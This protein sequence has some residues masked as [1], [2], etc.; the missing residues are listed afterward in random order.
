MWKEARLSAKG[1][2]LFTLKTTISIFFVIAF[3]LPSFVT[4]IFFWRHLHGISDEAH[5][6]FVRGYASV[7]KPIISEKEREYVSRAQL[8][9]AGF[10]Q[11]SIPLT[12]CAK[13]DKVGGIRF[14]HNDIG[15]GPFPDFVACRWWKLLNNKTSGWLLAEMTG[16]EPAV[17]KSFIPVIL[18][19]TNGETI[20]ALVDS[21]PL[22][23]SLG[24][25]MKSLLGSYSSKPVLIN[26][27]NEPIFAPNSQTDP[28]QRKE[29]KFEGSAR[30]KYG[31]ES[32][33][34]IGTELFKVGLLESDWDVSSDF[35]KVYFF[36]LYNFGLVLLT[37][38]AGLILVLRAI[39]EPIGSLASELGRA[40]KL[41]A[42]GA[43]VKAIGR[44][45]VPNR[46]KEV[47]DL[48]SGVNS[49]LTTV[50]ERDEKLGVLNGQLKEKEILARLGQLSTQI[51]H[52][53]QSPL[54]ALKAALIYISGFSDDERVLLRSAVNRIEDISNSL[55]QPSE[56]QS[57]ESRKEW[58]CLLTGIVSSVVSE[59]RLQYRPN[60]NVDLQF[61][62]SSNSY[63]VFGLINPSEFKRVLSNLI[64]NA[65][66]SMDQGTVFISVVS[67]EEKNVIQVRDNGRGIPSDVLQNLGERGAS[68]NKPHGT[69]LG[70]FHAKE[71]LKLWHASLEIESKEGV[72][73]SVS[74]VLPTT[75]APG[76]FL[77]YITVTSDTTIVAL[78]D[79]ASIHRVWQNRF[80][81]LSFSLKSYH[82]THPAE[83]E[84]YVNS[85]SIL[86][87]PRVFLVDFELL[88]QHETGLDLIVRLGIQKNSVLVTSHYEDPSVRSVCVSEGIKILPK[89]LASLVPIVQQT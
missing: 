53:I 15:A 73:T 16:T 83:L 10:F 42:D 3:T 20:V 76:W 34:K 8:C 43:G 61:V 56:P 81:G 37:G 47:A 32:E 4:S 13:K 29:N 11:N 88:G 39:S 35:G 55:K 26:E 44:I 75:A 19:R 69:G 49:L 17:C 64:D 74:I 12:L 63:G 58:T 14:L 80:K 48:Q 27:K 82:F 77:P 89:S 66:E 51:A 33:F 18:E 2:R 70:L 60:L 9:R 87:K 25:S 21:S 28:T 38:V 7:V 79:D 86:P 54:S 1:K 68:Y 23:S 6:V 72:G 52:D 67:T 31:H 46:I 36:L 65:V 71:T 50:K 40:R 62:S 59:K 24:T 57:V 85:S 22:F 5:D 78:D 84:N 45:E 41:V 30:V